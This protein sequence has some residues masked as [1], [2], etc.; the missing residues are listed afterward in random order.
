MKAADAS[1]DGCP[2]PARMSCCAPAPERNSGTQAP[3]LQAA[4]SSHPDFTLLKGHSAH[5]PGLP[6][7]VATAVTHAFEGARLKLPR[8]PLYLRNVVLLV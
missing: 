2:Q 8:D 1:H 5:V 7:L 3:P 4:A 6:A